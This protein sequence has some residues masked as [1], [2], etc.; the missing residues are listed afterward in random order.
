[1]PPAVDAAGDWPL[2]AATAHLVHPIRTQPDR[3]RARRPL[4]GHITDVHM[5]S[6]VSQRTRDRIEELTTTITIN[7]VEITFCPCRVVPETVLNLRALISETQKLWSETLGLDAFESLLRSAKGG[8]FFA[9]DVRLVRLQEDRPEMV[10]VW[11]PVPPD[12]PERLKVQ[13]IDTVEP[14]EFPHQTADTVRTGSVE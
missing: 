3:Q 12:Y 14:F 7:G 13:L 5:L 11:L 9:G 8:T 2:F 10:G 6:T 4:R 1:M